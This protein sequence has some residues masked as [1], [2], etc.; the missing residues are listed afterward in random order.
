MSP[1]LEKNEFI[2]EIASI[3]FIVYFVLLSKTSVEFYIVNE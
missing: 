2:I 3:Y 1:N